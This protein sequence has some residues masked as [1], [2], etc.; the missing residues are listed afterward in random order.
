[1]RK[2]I[3][4]IALLA[5]LGSAVVAGYGPIT[6]V[7]LLKQRSVSSTGPVAS[8]PIF[9]APAG[10]FRPVYAFYARSVAIGYRVV[11][12]PFTIAALLFHT[13]CVVALAGLIR[14]TSKDP[15]APLCAGLLFALHPLGAEPLCL[16][17]MQVVIPATLLCLLTGRALTMRRD[18]PSGGS[19]AYVSSGGVLESLRSIAVPWI[20]AGLFLLACLTLGWSLLLPLALVWAPLSSPSIKPR[21]RQI[22]L[23]GLI[24]VGVKVLSSHWQGRL[25]AAPDDWAQV[26]YRLLRGLALLTYPWTPPLGTIGGEPALYRPLLCLGAIVLLAWIARR[27]R[28]AT[29]AFVW[30]LVMG[31]PAS[32]EP[33]FRE[34]GYYVALAGFAWLVGLAI[35]A[36]FRKLGRKPRIG[37]SVL[38]VAVLYLLALQC[39]YRYSFFLAD[40]VLRSLPPLLP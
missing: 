18:P 40:S 34:G 19:A 28:G 30:I 29:M 3:P 21:V 31:V 6:G 13:L 12:L 37:L 26:G 24:A 33:R 2:P 17:T 10:T 27:E 23:Y 39:A 7:R 32:L 20:S 11:S 8:G 38:L 5:L 14:S 35:S 9:G 1:M 22:S 16:V 4:S 15:V 25:L 36:V